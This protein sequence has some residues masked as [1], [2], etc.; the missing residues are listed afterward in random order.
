[1]VHGCNYSLYRVTSFESNALALVA[2]ADVTSIPQQIHENG[3][4][5]LFLFLKV[6]IHDPLY[7][8]I[9]QAYTSI[10]IHGVE[11][12]TPSTK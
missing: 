7:L 12:I 5:V 11:G 1:M 3:F 4:S 10:Y 6:A 9:Q 2:A 8:Q